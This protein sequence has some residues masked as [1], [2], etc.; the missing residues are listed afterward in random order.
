VPPRVEALVPV[1][2][3]L[4]ERRILHIVVVI[5]GFVHEVVQFIAAVEVAATF[6]WAHGSALAG[7]GVIVPLTNFLI[8]RGFA[9]RTVV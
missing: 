3:E 8:C 1:F 5:E 9:A 7:L 6:T 4:L 2:I